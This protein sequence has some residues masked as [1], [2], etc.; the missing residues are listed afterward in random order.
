MKL[1]I[2]VLLNEEG[3]RDVGEGKFFC[4]HAQDVS[5]TCG[6]PAAWSWGRIRIHQKLHFLPDFQHCPNNKN[7]ETWEMVMNKLMKNADTL[8]QDPLV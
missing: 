6:S 3:R 2:L 5:H 8:F 1:S 7:L 4:L